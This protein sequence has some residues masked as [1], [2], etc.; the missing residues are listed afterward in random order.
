MKKEFLCTPGTYYLYTLVVFQHEKW[1]SSKCGKNNNLRIVSK[2]LAHHQTMTKTP[3]K[4][5]KDPHKTVGGVVHTRYPLKLITHVRTDART[6]GHGQR[7]MPFPHSTNSSDIGHTCISFGLAMGLES[8]KSFLMYFNAFI[9]SSVKKERRAPG[10][11]P[12]VFTNSTPLPI[13]AQ[14][15]TNARSGN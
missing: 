6:H 5:R 11:L 4:F 9:C 10:N 13:V 14:F 1:L 2:P 8:L 12:A 3:V 15:F 7:F